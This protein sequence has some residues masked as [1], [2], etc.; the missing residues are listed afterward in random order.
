MLFKIII[1]CLQIERSN[2]LESGV[3][4]NSTSASVTSERVEGFQ[5]GELVLSINTF[6]YKKCQ[7]N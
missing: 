6:I 4:Y 5:T 7:I 1:I 2:S 3:K